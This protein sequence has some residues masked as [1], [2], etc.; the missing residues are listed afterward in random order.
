MIWFGLN[1]VFAPVKDWLAGNLV[2]SEMNYSV[3]S[4]TLN[5]TIACREMVLIGCCSGRWINV[6]YVCR[7]LDQAFHQI[8]LLIF[9]RVDCHGHLTSIQLTSGFCFDIFLKYEGLYANVVLYAVVILCVCDTCGKLW[10]LLSPFTPSG[11][12]VI[13]VFS[14][15]TVQ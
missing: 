7:V 15:Q 8:V 9:F 12:H 14:R 2:I 11:S 3:S 6:L 5:H 1:S 4:G 13:L 10:P